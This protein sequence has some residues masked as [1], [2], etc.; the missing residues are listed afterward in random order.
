VTKATWEEIL[1]IQGAPLDPRLHPYGDACFA[2]GAQTIPYR[3]V[4]KL[5]V[6][7]SFFTCEEKHPDVKHADWWTDRVGNLTERT[8]VFDPTRGAHGNTWTGM[9]ILEGRYLRF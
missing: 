2:C 3:V 6:S 4:R 7:R 9:R 8:Q 1:D 5:E